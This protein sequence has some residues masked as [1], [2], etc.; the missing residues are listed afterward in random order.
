VSKGSSKSRNA[1]KGPPDGARGGRNKLVA[2][3]K[4]ARHDY[5]VEDTVEAGLVLTGTEVKSLRQGRCSLT[6]AYA[7]IDRGEMWLHA[8]HIPEYTEGTWNNHAP[9]R[10]RKLLLHRKQIDSLAGRTREGGLALVPLSLY[11]KDGRAK[12]ELALA[13]GRKAHDKRQ[14]LAERDAQREMRY[15]L[16]R[17][18]KQGRS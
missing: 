14:V 1:A 11:F 2:Q 5:S 6:D 12:V 10:D 17:A 7:T 13:R 18:L 9:R 3:N 16:G 8:A 15:A 4:K